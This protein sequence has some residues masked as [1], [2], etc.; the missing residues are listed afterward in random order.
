V[1]QP[2]ANH[3]WQQ[4]LDLLAAA[5]PDVCAG[6]YHR[7]VWSA[8]RHPSGCSVPGGHASWCTIYRVRLE[9]VRIDDDRRRRRIYG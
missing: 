4:I 5:D 7:W 9:V 3:Q 6:A 2:L 1:K 8:K